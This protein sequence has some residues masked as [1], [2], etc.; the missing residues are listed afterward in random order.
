MWILMWAADAANP[1]KF[2]QTNK[3]KRSYK[4]RNENA[5]LLMDCHR[6]I[7]ELFDEWEVPDS[8]E[9]FCYAMKAMSNIKARI[10]ARLNLPTK[11]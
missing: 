1:V 2:M 8:P 3:T 6:A 5:K 7:Q 4:P 10:A 11:P 9:G